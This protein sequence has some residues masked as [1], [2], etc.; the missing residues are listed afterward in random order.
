MN[1]NLVVEIYVP[2]KS[3]HGVF[4]TGYPLRKDLILTARHVVCPQDRDNTQPIEIRFENQDWHP[5]GSELA[6]ESDADLDVALIQC[7]F[8]N[9]FT[10]EVFGFLSTDRPQDHSQW[11]SA[12]FADAGIVDRN[13]KPRLVSVSGEVYSAPDSDNQFELG[14]VF[15]PDLQEGWRG[16]SGSPVF[17]HGRIIGVI[18]VCP[19]NF[20]AARLRASPVWKLLEDPKFREAVGYEDQIKRREKFENRIVQ[21][22][23]ESEVAI[24]ILGKK[25]NPPLNSVGIDRIGQARNCAHRLLD[26][27]VADAIQACKN[28]HDDLVEQRRIDDTRVITDLLQLLIPAIYDHGVIEAVRN[29]RFDVDAALIELPAGLRSVAEVIMAGSDRR[30]TCFRDD[31]ERFPEGIY[32][33]PLPPEGGFDGDGQAFRAAWNEHLANQ[34]GP[35]SAPN[36]RE[37][38][39][40]YMV[41]RFAEMEPRARTRHPSE[42]V[43]DA[44]DELE[45]RAKEQG[46]TYYFLTDAPA[47]FQ[48]RQAL[49]NLIAD[50]KKDYPA[51][52]FLQLNDDR[53]LERKEKR[54]FRPL[55]DILSK[56]QEAP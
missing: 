41:K 46:R 49:R 28:A 14:A 23:E 27:G 2:T 1:K 51:V 55:F 52:V 20:R 10:K 36:L 16:I 22:L 38:W 5:C 31:R 42:Y 44:A 50:L 37:A 35:A 32:S 4:G 17:V 54:E 12:G 21:I 39:D 33:L 43:Q 56:Q 6:W 25:F 53:E 30:A 18:V 13:K 26:L 34:F 24:Q 11:S 48:A 47:N 19:P 40:E 3:G 7:D 29:R 8:P 15:P 45:Y 9:S